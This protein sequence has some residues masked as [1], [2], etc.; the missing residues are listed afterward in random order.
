MLHRSSFLFILLVKESFGKYPLDCY[1]ESVSCYAH[2]YLSLPVCLG[3]LAVR[4]YSQING[5]IL[6]LSLTKS[7]FP[8][9][10]ETSR[11]E[12][13]PNVSLYL[14]MFTQVTEQKG[15]KSEELPHTEHWP[16]KKRQDSQ[17]RFVD[18]LVVF[19]HPVR[20]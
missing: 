11:V 6:S 13:V 4:F 14:H 17:R 5:Q 8:L 1:L 20:S 2:W 12:G 15:M 3:C 7:L 19:Q 18:I 16:Q 10:E 9:C